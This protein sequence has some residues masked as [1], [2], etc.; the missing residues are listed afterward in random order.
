GAAGRVVAVARRGREDGL[1]RRGQRHRFDAV[2]RVADQLVVAVGG[3]DGD[4]VVQ[5][6][7]GGVAGAGVVVQVVV[8]RGGDEDHP[9]GAGVLDG[10]QQS[11]VVAGPVPAVVRD[12]RPVGDGVVEAGDELGGGGVA[13]G[14]QGLDRHQRH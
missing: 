3:G 13:G 9:V 8:A 5:G 10:R 1:A 2:V 4:D 12:L 11:R 7:A 6:E 14:V